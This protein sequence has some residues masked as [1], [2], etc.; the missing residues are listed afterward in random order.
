MVESKFAIK[1]IDHKA[2]HGRIVREK[3]FDPFGE[4]EDA[5]VYIVPYSCR[6]S[7]CGKTAAFSSSDADMYGRRE[8]MPALSIKF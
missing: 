6:V 7:R 4:G 1:E 3:E 5:S 8:T 2:I